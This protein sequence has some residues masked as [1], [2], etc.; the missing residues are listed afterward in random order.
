MK[1]VT[2]YTDGKAAQPLSVCQKSLSLRA[3]SQTGVA[4]CILGSAVETKID[5]TAA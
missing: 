4:I 5:A 2:I 1:T 3:S